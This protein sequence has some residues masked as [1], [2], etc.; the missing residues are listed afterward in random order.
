MHNLVCINE[1]HSNCTSINSAN[2]Y[3][4]VIYAGIGDGFILMMDGV[5]EL[6]VRIIV[7]F[8]LPAIIGYTGICLARDCSMYSFGNKIL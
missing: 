7:A 4:I 5:A 3:I 6:L 1:V 8:T 2:A